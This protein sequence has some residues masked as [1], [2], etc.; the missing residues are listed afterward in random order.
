MHDTHP[1]SNAKR[2][3]TYEFRLEDFPEQTLGN[4][5]EDTTDRI[6]YERRTEE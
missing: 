5:G 1:S 2:G 4:I 3:T 6:I